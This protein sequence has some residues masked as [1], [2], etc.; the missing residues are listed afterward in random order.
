MLS[1]Y[2]TLL[3]LEDQQLPTAAAVVSAAEAYSSQPVLWVGAPVRVADNSS[4]A[5]LPEWFEPFCQGCTWT[6][7]SWEPQE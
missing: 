2:D 4:F 1:L 7:D 5:P 6:A 3:P